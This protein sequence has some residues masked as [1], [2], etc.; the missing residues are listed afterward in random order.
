[1]VGRRLCARR[2]ILRDRGQLHAGQIS[3]IRT[4]VGND[5]QLVRN[6]NSAAQRF[7]HAER[8]ANIGTDHGSDAVGRHLVE[9]IADRTMI[10]GKI[11]HFAS[12]NILVFHA[13][14]GQ[15]LFQRE[16]VAHRRERGLSQIERSFLDFSARSQIEELISRTANHHHMFGTIADQHLR[17]QSP[18]LLV[19]GSNRRNTVS[20]HTV[21]RD[22][23]A[24]NRRPIIAGM[25]SV[26]THD[27]AV[28]HVPTQHVDILDFAVRLIC[29]RAQHSA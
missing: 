28:H 12:F 3:Q 14:G 20:K 24:M 7:A 16:V 25:R 18:T 23:R 9:R 21:E 4:I 22:D 27:D 15:F 2:E 29:G 8:R 5:L 6:G 13:C 1:M 26:R 11:H 17:N 10:A 19:V